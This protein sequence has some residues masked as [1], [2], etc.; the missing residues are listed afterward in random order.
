VGYVHLF[1]L[2][3]MQVDK[4]LKGAKPANLPWE[5]PTEFELVLNMKTAKALGVSIPESIMVRATKVIR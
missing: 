3:A 5:Q 4:I 2:A 1:K